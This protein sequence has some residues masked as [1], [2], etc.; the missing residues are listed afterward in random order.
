MFENLADLRPLLAVLP[1]GVRCIVATGIG[2]VLARQAQ[3]LTPW[4]EVRWARRP[5]PPPGDDGL[6][7][8]EYT[9][10]FFRDKPSRLLQA[11]TDSL[12]AG[13]WPEAT[14]QAAP[15]VRVV[16]TLNPAEADS[17]VRALL[18]AADRRSVQHGSAWLRQFCATV[19]LHGGIARLHVLYDGESPLAVWPVIN[20]PRRPGGEVAALANYYT[21]LYAP[22]LS[23]GLYAKDL[24]PLL[25]HALR[26]AGGAAAIRLAPMDGAGREFALMRDAMRAAGLVVF[27]YPCF[28]NWYLP[29][30]AYDWAGYLGSRS[31]GLR[32][33]LK[34]L[35][36]KFQAEQHGRMELITGGSRLE[37]GIDAYE[38][39]Y[40]QSWKVPEPHPQFMPGLMR[41]C[42]GRGWLR[43]GVAWAGE[44][45]AAA[46]FWIVAHGRADIFKVAYDDA[47][48]RYSVGSLLT[49][50]LMRHVLEDDR[51]Q[52]VDF[53][54]GDD[55][56]K[57]GW[58]D[59]RR[60]RW[61]MVG[62]RPWSLSG[63]AGIAR[64]VAASLRDVVSLPK[65][66]EQR[67]DGPKVGVQTDP[68]ATR[69][70]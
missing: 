60:E 58:M 64:R 20:P 32:N 50:F 47:F 4:C 42:A 13:W 12:R 38:R 48:A 36:A 14:A 61:G 62:Y 53:L 41:A 15:A 66:S 11:L 2:A 70:A 59:A 18:D 68:S 46:Q 10:T 7:E 37:A 1:L 39:V 26:D 28:G 65:D 49:G 8:D 25:R 3:E 56:Y 52:E 30:A 35:G 63:M 45:P 23:P 21:S 57:R 24:V 19:D 51:V 22:S 9:L 67:R 31:T 27:E 16:R 44:Q 55:A 69:A 43:L 54:M 6:A 40:R 17:R 33:T 5:V 34:R 29:A